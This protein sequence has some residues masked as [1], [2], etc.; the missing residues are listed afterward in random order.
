MLSYPKWTAQK[1]LINIK[2]DSKFQ[3]NGWPRKIY[4]V[5]IHSPRWASRIAPW[6]FT[7]DLAKIKLAKYLCSEKVS[8]L[9]TVNIRGETWDRSRTAGCRACPR[10]GRKRSAR[11]AYRWP[12]PGASSPAEGSA[13]SRSL[14]PPSRGRCPWREGSSCRRSGGSL[15]TGRRTWASA[16][17][18]LLRDLKKIAILYRGVEQ[19]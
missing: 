14:L 18:R 6:A 4:Y 11:S 15:R 12:K 16:V 2:V 5:Y 9:S 1:L 7:K 10:P 17:P 8:C 19:L 13:S 3:K